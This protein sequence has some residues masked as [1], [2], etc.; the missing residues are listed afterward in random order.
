[1][2]DLLV[3]VALLLAPSMA[4]RSRLNLAA[5]RSWMPTSLRQ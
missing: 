3:A 1:V 4:L 5:D 2:T